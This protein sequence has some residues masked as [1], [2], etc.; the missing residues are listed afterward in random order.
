MRNILVARTNHTN[1]DVLE[2]VYKLGRCDDPRNGWVQLKGRPAV[3]MVCTHHQALALSLRRSARNGSWRLAHFV[4][5]PSRAIISQHLYMQRLL[6]VGAAHDA[7]S[8][9]EQRVFQ[10]HMVKGEL[11]AAWK[12]S[13]DHMAGENPFGPAR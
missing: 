11:A 13:I 5:R 12:L 9:T 8:S 7:G 1:V 6:K 3:R 4:R 2:D 10:Q